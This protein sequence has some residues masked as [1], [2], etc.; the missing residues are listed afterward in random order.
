MY[1]GEIIGFLII[2]LITGV[3]VQ[4]PDTIPHSFYLASASYKEI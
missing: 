3:F 4:R 2:C 1:R